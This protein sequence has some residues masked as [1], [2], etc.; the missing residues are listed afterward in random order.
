[1]PSQL[2]AISYWGFGII[3]FA[4]VAAMGV[5]VI[6]LALDDPV[7]NPN[8][9]LSKKQREELEGKYGHWAVQTAL[10]VVPYRDIKAVEREAKRLSESRFYRR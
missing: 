1:M 10:S 3:G 5:S 4:A 7:G 9:W 2:D 8:G 6:R